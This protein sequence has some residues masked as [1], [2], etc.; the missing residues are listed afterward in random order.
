LERSEGAQRGREAPKFNPASFA[1]SLAISLLLTGAILFGMPRVVPALD[2]EGSAGMM[3]AVP[4]WFV[5]GFLV[6]LIAPPGSLVELVCAVLFV[7]APTA[8]LLFEG[9]TVKTMPAVLYAVLA[10]VG[11]L[12]AVI[13]A[14]LGERWQRGAGARPSP[15]S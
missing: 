6:G 7:A 5:G 9:Q 1:T 12:F 14:H 13:G 2:F 15:R 3:V 11:L 8:F 10:L 4:T